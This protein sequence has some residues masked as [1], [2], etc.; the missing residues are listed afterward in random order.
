M[1]KKEMKKPFKILSIIMT[2]QIFAIIFAGFFIGFTPLSFGQTTTST[3][4][5]STSA[6]SE[7]TTATFSITGGFASNIVKEEK[8]QSSFGTD[9]YKATITWSTDKDAD[10]HVVASYILFGN[11]LMPLY[12][13]ASNN[14]LTKNHSLN[15]EGLSAGKTYYYYVYSKD[16]NKNTVT[17]DTG[18]WI[19]SHSFTT[20]GAT[21]SITTGTAETAGTSGSGGTTGAT[22]LSLQT[23]APAW[24]SLQI[25]T[26]DPVV[27]STTYGTFSILNVFKYAMG[28]IGIVALGAVI[29]GG[30][31]RITAAANPSNISEGNSYILGAIMGIV[32]L[33][34]A[35]IIFNTINPQI[36]NIGI[37]EESLSGIEDIE[38]TLYSWQST[39]T[40]STSS[41][42]AYNSSPVSSAE[43]IRASLNIAGIDY[44]NPAVQNALKENNITWNQLNTITAYLTKGNTHASEVFILTAGAGTESGSI[45]LN[46]KKNT[47]LDDYFKSKKFS[48][49]VSGA[50]IKEEATYWVIQIPKQ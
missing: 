27:S 47:G 45:I 4:A 49:Y 11:Y 46:F 42:I 35:A 14:A 23:T 10:S 31:L 3:I 2:V 21:D 17:T 29:Y 13:N 50:T 12:V 18:D 9:T 1:Q 33:A 36:A 5:T 39:S 22:S 41:A 40:V 26:T 30:I 38:P 8:S 15:L 37:T 24:A 32:L 7:L 20:P 16:A 6:T 44:T 19:S 43:M 48:E 34:G 25:G 28:F